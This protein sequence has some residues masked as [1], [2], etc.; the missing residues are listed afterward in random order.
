MM[1]V[2]WHSP[3]GAAA[4]FG[5][6]TGLHIIAILAYRFYLVITGKARANSFASSRNEV[7][8]FQ[9]GA[10]A[11]SK[12]D[13]E[14]SKKDNTTNSDNNNVTSLQTIM[15]RIGQ[16]HA[17]C[18]ENFPLFF[19]LVMLNA[20]TGGPNISNLSWL[21]VYFRVAQTICHLHG[22]TEEHCMLR[23]ALFVTQFVFLAVMTY[24]TIEMGN[25]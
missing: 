21:L 4:A 18:M 16:S 15:L 22:N 11:G 23:Y 12:S 2:A 7:S 6:W 17:N 14:D 5:I 3:L 8:L 20:V 13:L 9:R 19:A 1:A 24:Q 25:H 10:A